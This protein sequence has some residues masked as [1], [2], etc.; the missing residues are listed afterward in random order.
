M[1]AIN[2]YTK[3]IDALLHSRLNQTKQD[4]INLENRP[5]AT[6]GWLSWHSNYL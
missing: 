5:V 2:M 3:I 4:Y 6:D 1:K